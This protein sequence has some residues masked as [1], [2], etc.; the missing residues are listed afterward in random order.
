MCT[1]ILLELR[2]KR[3]YIGNTVN[4]SETGIY[5]EIGYQAIAVELHE[6]GLLHLMPLVS[7]NGIPCKVTRLTATG[8]A[9]QFIADPSTEFSSQL[10]PLRLSF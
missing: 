4:V 3:G 2:D 7:G 8:I 6:I 5:F 10:A 9:I 1:R